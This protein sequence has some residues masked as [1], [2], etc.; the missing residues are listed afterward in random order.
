MGGDGNDASMHSVMSD[1]VNAIGSVSALNNASNL[2]RNQR[3]RCC[4][5]ATPPPPL[6]L[7]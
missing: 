4:I 3:M 1:L 5:V 6:R 7:F 2:G